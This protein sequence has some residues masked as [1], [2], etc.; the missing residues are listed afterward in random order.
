VCVLANWAAAQAPPYPKHN[1]AVSYRVVPN[2]PQ[3]PDSVAK[4]E[5][6]SGLAV[7]AQDRVWSLNRGED[8]VQVYE[9][10]GKFV[11]TWGRTTIKTGHHLKLDAQGNVWLADIGLH[12][13]RKFSPSGEVLLTLGTP[14]EKGC[15][16]THLYMPTD[17]AITPQG[18]VFVSDGYGNARVVHFDKQGKFVKAWGELGSRPGQFSLVHA[19]ALDSQ[20]KLYVADRNNVRVQVFNQDGKLLDVWSDVITPWGFAVGKQDE[21]WVCG[22]SPMPWWEAHE[23]DTPLGCPP[24]DQLVMRFDPSG[25]L[26]QLW[27]FPKN[28]DGQERP[29]ML[30]WVHCVAVDSQG[31]L[32]LG[33]IM[34][35]RLQKFSRVAP[36]QDG[37]AVT[38]SN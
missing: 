30:N 9:A 25:R 8:P 37:P 19:I 1:A 21:I 10:D 23:Y 7:D 20:G 27:T 36:D 17:M 16:A 5:A 15:D 33:D 24:K 38:S 4:W 34:G 3:R 6:M 18:D 35:K 22:S 13:V 26:R 28:L 29:G 32:Y 31:N 2:W 11:R 12:V 14:G